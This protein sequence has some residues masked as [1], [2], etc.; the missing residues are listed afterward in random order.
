MLSSPVLV[1]FPGG[2]FKYGG[3]DF[4]YLDN[5]PIQLASQ[6]GLI[7]VTVNYR[8]GPLGNCNHSQEDINYKEEDLFFSSRI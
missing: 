3:K 2:E 6:S 8:L 5:L 1:Y 7:F 4:Y